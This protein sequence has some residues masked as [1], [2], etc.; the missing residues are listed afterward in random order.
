M[1]VSSKLINWWYNV[2]S[3]SAITHMSSSRLLSGII[4]S[5]ATSTSIGN[6]SEFVSLNTGGGAHKK[7]DGIAQG[8]DIQGKGIVKYLLQM[9]CG[10]EVTLRSHAY[11]VPEL[12]RHLV[13]LTTKLQ[14]HRWA[15]RLSCLSWEQNSRGSHRFQQLRENLDPTRWS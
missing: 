1:Q 6:R 9:D 5:G 14:Y 4:N 7:L 3:A 11:W 13:A 10:S 15:P 2:A 12:L 8:L